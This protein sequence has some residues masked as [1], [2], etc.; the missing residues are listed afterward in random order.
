MKNYKELKKE[1]EIPEVMSFKEASKPENMDQI[2]ENNKSL[3]KFTETSDK[4]DSI[5][6]PTL[7]ETKDFDTEFAS[8]VKFIP[9]ETIRKN[10]EKN[11]DIIKEFKSIYDKDQ[12]DARNEK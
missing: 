2:I 8:Y 7:P 11:K 1:L 5:S 6:A 9:D 10:I 3:K 12:E 4:F